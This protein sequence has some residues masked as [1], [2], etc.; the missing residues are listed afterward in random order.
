MV[1]LFETKYALECNDDE[2]SV[3]ICIFL[4]AFPDDMHNPFYYIVSVVEHTTREK[5]FFLDGYIFFLAPVTEGYWVEHD[6]CNPLVLSIGTILF[7]IEYTR[8][9]RKSS[10]RTKAKNSLEHYHILVLFQ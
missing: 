1:T 9:G 5:R 6:L 10:F 8:K 7:C 4:I 3:N 2:F